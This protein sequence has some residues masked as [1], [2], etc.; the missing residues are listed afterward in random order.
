MIAMY[1]L[2]V[3]LFCLVRARVGLDVLTQG[4]GL[5]SL[6][7]QTPQVEGQRA[8]Y[9]RPSLLPSYRSGDP[10]HAAPSHESREKMPSRMTAPFRRKQSK[11]D[12]AILALALSFV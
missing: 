10:P 11:K 1:K 4:S 3:K 8:V 7:R 5:A 9:G 2:F 12:I 6:P